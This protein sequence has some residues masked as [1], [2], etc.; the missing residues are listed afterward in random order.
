MIKEIGFSAVWK[1][2]VATSTDA[3]RANLPFTLMDYFPEDYLLII[4]G[5]PP[6]PYPSTSY[7]TRV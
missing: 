2:T 4:D 1:T 6:K 5:E 3:T 7:V